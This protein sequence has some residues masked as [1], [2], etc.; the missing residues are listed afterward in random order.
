MLAKTP[1]TLL[2]PMLAFLVILSLVIGV[3]VTKSIDKKRATEIPEAVVVQKED[4]EGALVSDFP[5]M[6]IYP[7]SELLRTYRKS[8]DGKVGYEGVWQSEDSS[9]EVMGWYIK[10]LTS[11]DW[12]VVEEPYDP[13]ADGEQFLVVEKEGITLNLTIEN[14]GG[15][16]SIY[17]EFPVR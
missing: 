1:K 6:P 16:T 7:N 5:S 14:E 13:L 8:E 9:P 12:V 10:S 4:L 2:F 3:F 15:L 17:A 11:S